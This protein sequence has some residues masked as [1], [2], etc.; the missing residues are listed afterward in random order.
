MTALEIFAGAGGAALGLHAAGFA[1]LALVEWDRDACS[2]LR[3]AVAAGLLDGEVLE[4]DVRAVDWTPYAGRV[5]LLWASPPCQAWSAA[6]KRLGA[7][8]ERNLW[9]ATLDVLDAVRPTW[10]LCEN[11]PGLTTHAA[12][13]HEGDPDRRQSNPQACPGCYWLGV[14]LPAFRARFAVVDFRILDAADYGVPQHRRRVFLVAGPRSIRWPAPTHG[15]P[16][17]GPRLF[18][19]PAPWVTIRE[20]LG[21]VVVG[22]GTNPHGPG[23]GHERTARDV[24]DEPATTIPAVNAG[25]NEL[26]SPVARTSQSSGRARGRVPVESSI[27]SSSPSVRAQEGRGLCILDAPADTI[28]G[29]SQASHVNGRSAL[30]ASA[31]RRA[32][33]A[34]AG[35]RRLTV[36]ECARL[37]AFP[38]DW[39]WQGTLTSRFRCVGNAVPP[40]LARLLAEAIL[41]ASPEP[42]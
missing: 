26:R 1:H 33:Y 32:K 36:L 25:N 5:D 22:A 18:G 28:A 19:A 11:V 7:A 16:V 9:P 2:T 3:A 17:D 12:A 15:D 42:P 21:I 35:L 30:S 13:A 14:I 6:G 31:D 29:G 8:D 39:P 27:D 38:D 24:S 34:E 23:R 40:P 41:A 37:Q 4:G 20:A 10:A